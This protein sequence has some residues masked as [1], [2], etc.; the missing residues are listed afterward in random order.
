ML[1]F[2][3]TVIALILL[4]LAFFVPALFRKNTLEADTFDQQNILIARQRLK[5]LK[6]DLEA[7]TIEAQ[8][9][10]QVRADLENTLAAD[11]SVTSQTIA[12]TETEPAQNSKGLA[13]ILLVLV[14]FLA[15]LTYAQLGEFDAITGKIAAQQAAESSGHDQ[16]MSIEQA[17]EQLSARLEQEPDNAEGWYMLGRSYMAVQRYNEA[18]AAYKRS[19]ELFPGNADLLLSYADAL[20][21]SEGRRL[22]GKAYTVINQALSIQPDNMQG[23]WMAGMAA[24]ETGDFKQALTHWYKLYPLLNNNIEGQT[25]LRS[26]ISNVESN[27]TPAEVAAVKSAA[28]A[29]VAQP[30]ADNGVGIKVNVSLDEALY[31]KVSVNDTLFIFAKAMQGP[32]MPLA[33]VR[34]QA[35]SLPVDV[36]LNDAMAMMPD[37]KLSKFETVKVAAIIS[38]SGQAGMQPG[39]LFGEV[40]SVDVNTKQTINIVINQIK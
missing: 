11:L 33:A 16:S 3:T 5:E 28:P 22:S 40:S 23:L 14:P 19:V 38:K 9:Y 36:V 25:Q 1:A 2:V 17:I 32:P 12:G 18:V 6:Q 4:A 15:I 20:A 31:E 29:P 39:D 26:M 37:M 8:E 7:G 30:L 27:M 10:E 13:I 24:S 21:M 35:G 34:Q